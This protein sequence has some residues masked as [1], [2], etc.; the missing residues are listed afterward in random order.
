MR[1]KDRK[2]RYVM[3]DSDPLIKACKRGDDS[4]IRELL[5]LQEPEDLVEYVNARDK[6]GSTPIFHTCW[7]GQSQSHLVLL[8]CFPR[9]VERWRPVPRRRWLCPLRHALPRSEGAAHVLPLDFM[10][11]LLRSLLF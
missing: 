6:N 5:G 4:R 1:K 10:P 8:F 11:I 9:F 2:V 3:A 7:P